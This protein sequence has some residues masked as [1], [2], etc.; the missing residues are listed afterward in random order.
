MDYRISAE[1]DNFNFAER[2]GINIRHQVGDVKRISV[3][4][5][6]DT[7]TDDFYRATNQSSFYFPY[8]HITNTDHDAI[9]RRP[10]VLEVMC[11]QDQL[12]PV[13]KLLIGYGG[14]NVQDSPHTTS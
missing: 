8:Y 3:K 2:T 13:K 12:A 10:A 6:Q 7:G 14:L 4:Q 9:G 1:F 11:E 5:T